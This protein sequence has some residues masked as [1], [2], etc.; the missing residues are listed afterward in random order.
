MIRLDGQ[1]GHGSFQAQPPR[2]KV[3]DSQKHNYHPAWCCSAQGLDELYA[4]S[5]VQEQRARLDAEGEV[6]AVKLD[7]E[8]ER[9]QRINATTELSRC[10][11]R[12]QELQIALTEQRCEAE[13]AVTQLQEARAQIESLGSALRETRKVYAECAHV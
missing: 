4:C 8:R 13:D 5:A 6:K 10:T 1:T 7:F 3:S 12:V 2:P 11:P 9:A